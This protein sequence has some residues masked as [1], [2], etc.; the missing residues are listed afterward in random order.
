[1]I[2]ATASLTRKDAARRREANFENEAYE[3]SGTRQGSKS[4]TWPRTPLGAIVRQPE[5][6]D[7]G[8]AQLEFQVRHDPLTRLP[9]R[10]LFIDLTRDALARIPRNRGLLALLAIDL[11]HFAEVATRFGDRSG[12][13]SGDDVLTEVA[14]RLD[15]SLRTRSGS[16]RSKNTLGHLGG[17]RFL[18]ICEEVGDADAAEIVAERIAATLGASMQLAGESVNLTAGLGIALTR[19]PECDPEPLIREAESAMRLA[20]QRG[21]GRHETFTGVMRAQRLRRM[22]DEL[23]LREA[24]MR[25]EFRVVYQPKVSLT[26]GRMTGVEALLRWDNPE[27]GI[28][29]P[30]EFTPLVEA[31]GLSVPIGAW[32]LDQTCRDAS[33]WQQATPGALALRIAV[34]LSSSQFEPG[35]AT[36]FQSILAAAR[37]APSSICLQ[38]TESTVLHDTERA[39]SMLRELKALGMHVALD[40]FGTGFSSL[41]S[42]TRFLLDELKIDRSLIDGLG[43]D[44]ETSAIVAALVAMA[45]ALDLRVVADGVQTADQAAVLRRVGCDEA[46]GSYFAPPETADEIVTRLDAKAA[47]GNGDAASETGQPEQLHQTRVLVVDDVEDVRVLARSSLVAVGMSVAE[48]SSGEDALRITRRFAPDC[49]VL[50]INLP[51][52]SGLEV[53]RIIRADRR[54]AHVAILMLTGDAEA[55]GKVTAFSL[56][57]DDYMVKPFRPRDLVTRVNDAIRRRADM[58]TATSVS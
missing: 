16:Q 25:D 23:A 18:V 8:E 47:A 40:N 14:R 44:T 1:L 41:A 49:V 42:L 54:N 10:S 12:D 19:D 51:G 24:L 32:V 5:F 45:H 11:D 50:D 20:K 22:G 4:R 55:T 7:P 15:T 2:D 13:Y 48:A 34:N 9:N 6:A 31:L 57:A 21:S 58:R 28:V 52:I 39:I 38:V 17:D 56:K 30:L 33:S 27:R 36:T 35:L 53:C 26:T 29:P 3:D 37:V 43:P 46:Q